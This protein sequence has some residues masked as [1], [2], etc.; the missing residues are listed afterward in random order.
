VV[1]SLKSPSTSADWEAY[2][3][4]RRKVLWEARGQF[5]VYDDAHPD[6]YKEGHF[7]KLLLFES[8]P[9]GVV[10]I[11]IVGTVGWLRR[12]AIAE[13]LQRQGHGSQLIR[14]A[15]QFAR[16]RGVSRIQ[17][18][19]DRDAIPFYERFGFRRVNSGGT[20]LA[21]DL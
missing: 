13:P 8:E 16:E 14:L 15:E 9:I 3:S 7:P 17:S 2:H 10:R 4:I 12:L 6:E 20:L 1:Y 21:K 11:D 19:V 18:D 5:G